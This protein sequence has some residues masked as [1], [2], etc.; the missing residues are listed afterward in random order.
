MEQFIGLELSAHISL[1]FYPQRV[2]PLSSAA[3]T[4]LR[5]RPDFSASRG[6]ILPDSET[7]FLVQGSSTRPPSEARMTKQPE[8]QSDT[9]LVPIAALGQNKHL[10]GAAERIMTNEFMIVGGNFEK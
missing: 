7:I 4:G 2:S 9:Q 3:T 8:L 1:A 6:P 5:A 10:V